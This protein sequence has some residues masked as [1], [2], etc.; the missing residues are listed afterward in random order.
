MK[1]LIPYIFF[2]CLMTGFISCGSNSDNESLSNP[3]QTDDPNA[4][5]PEAIRAED[6]MNAIAHAPG[7]IQDSAEAARSQ[8]IESGN[9]IDSLQ[10]K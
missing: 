6:S 1:K 10:K 3:D 7:E 4:R 2:C 9:H 8:A 5:N